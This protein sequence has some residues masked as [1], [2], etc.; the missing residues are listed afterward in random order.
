[1]KEKQLYITAMSPQYWRSTNEVLLLVSDPCW[2][3]FRMMT[4]YMT[5]TRDMIHLK[6]GAKITKTG[7][8]MK[9]HLNKGTSKE[10]MVYVKFAQI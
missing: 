10:A 4:A 3:L 8:Q 1:M 2:F 9:E 6:A 5:E 7:T